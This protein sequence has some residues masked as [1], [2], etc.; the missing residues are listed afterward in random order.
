MCSPH[1]PRTELQALKASARPV[2]TELAGIVFEEGDDDA[3]TLQK[4]AAVDYA[5]LGGTM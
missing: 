2:S 1:V 4:A 3:T 5:T